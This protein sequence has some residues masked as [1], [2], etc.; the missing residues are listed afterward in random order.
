VRASRPVPLLL[1]L[2]TLALAGS[3]GTYTVRWGDTLGGIAKQFGV[4]VQDFV[5]A[6]G[7]RDPDHIREGQVL[8]VPA[9]VAAQP[10]AAVTPAVSPGTV[11]VAPGETLSG[12]ARRHGT[13]VAAI[14][15]LNG[16]RDVDHIRDGTVLRIPAGAAP[17]ATW[18]CP[19]RGPIRYI[20]RFGDPRGGRSHQ[21]VDMAAPRG[22]PVVA[23]VGGEL[24][25]H[26]NTRG[27]N[28][29][30]LRGDNGDTYYGAHLD[31]YVGAGGRV[32]IGQQI[33]TVGSSGNAIGGVSHLHFE[34]MPG[35]GASVDPMPL[36]VRACQGA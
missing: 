34:R 14:A 19:V 17:A 8:N 23:N 32:G 29:Y 25:R 4:S 7:L 28:A 15:S 12:I 5:T 22:T 18:V 6:N 36:L 33:G 11:R 13:T 10:I 24:E 31:G 21:G 20:G 1:A 2:L 3:A 26:P 9:R 16:I 27:G 35:G 30:Y